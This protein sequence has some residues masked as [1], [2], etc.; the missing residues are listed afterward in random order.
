M[1]VEV[2]DPAMNS[3]YGLSRREVAV[4]KLIAEGMTDEQ[5][6][7]ELLISLDVV[8]GSVASL[9]GKMGSD[10]RTEAAVRAMKEGLPAC[11]DG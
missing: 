3:S 7:E 9:L 1:T 11:A 6:A 5:I 4:L 2:H 10:S 8:K